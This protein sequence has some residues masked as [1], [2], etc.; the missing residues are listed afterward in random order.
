VA[1]YGYL[2]SDWPRQIS[3]VGGRGREKV[4]N[5]NEKIKQSFNSI[6][7]LIEEYLKVIDYGGIQR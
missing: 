6:F 1:V 3:W 4:I 7:D 2:S 5:T